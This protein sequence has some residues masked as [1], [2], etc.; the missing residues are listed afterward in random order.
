MNI[1]VIFTVQNKLV[2]PLERTVAKEESHS[3]SVTPIHAT[4][5]S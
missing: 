5:I 1:N 2:K 4:I 3:E